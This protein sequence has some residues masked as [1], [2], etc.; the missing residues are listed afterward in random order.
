V[1]SAGGASA[2][3]PGTGDTVVVRSIAG[4]AH[5][6]AGRSTDYD[7]LLEAIGEARIVLLGEDTHGTREFYLER[8]RITQ[9]LI[10]E[11][12]FAGVVIESDWPPTARVGAALESGATDREID[13]ALRAFNRF[14]LWMWRNAEFTTLLRWIRDH[15]A[16]QP[17]GAAR[18]QLRGMDLSEL[19]QGVAE[20]TG[21][22]EAVDPGAAARIRDRYAC[23]APIGFDPQRYG[24]ILADKSRADCSGPVQCVLTELV[25][26]GAAE[27][28]GSSSAARDADPRFFSALQSARTVRNAEEYFRAL[29]ADPAASWNIRDTHMAAIVDNLLAHLDAISASRPG[30]VIWAHNAHVG[31]T[32]A[33]A[34]GDAGNWSL[35]QLLRE[36]YP[37]RVFSIGFTTSTGRVHAATNWGERGRAKTLRRPIPGSHAALMSRTGIARF[38]CVFAESPALREM[39][40]LSRPQRGIGVRYLP[41]LERAGHYYDARLS[42]QF[43]AV[44]H[45]ERTSALHPR[46][47]R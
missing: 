19:A 5:R 13:A 25:T 38:Y 20:V 17:A 6:I 3:G 45:I 4:A 16:R 34:R 7:R 15:N 47:S 11:R 46:I 18:V 36:R 32:R 2:A 21:W 40:A 23:L 10:A 31:D 33:S 26:S 14:P 27:G 42:L 9:R 30:I 28:T 12:G 1:L 43:D 22:A 39:L 29:H 35:G 41:R 37:E 24:T 44:V 8:A